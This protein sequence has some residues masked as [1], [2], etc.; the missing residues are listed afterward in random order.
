MI[1]IGERFPQQNLPS[2]FLVM[3]TFSY[4]I[5]IIAV[6]V[7]LLIAFLGKQLFVIVPV[8][9][10]AVAT[11]FGKPQSNIF[12]EGIHVPVNPLYD[13]TFFDT[14]AKTLKE[15]AAVPSQD[16]LKTSI[17]VSVQYRIDGSKA[18]KILQETGRAENAIEIH[19]KPK[20]RSLLREQGKTIKNAEDFFSD[21]TQTLLQGTLQESLSKF[22]DDKGIIV[23]EVL[24]R[25]INLPVS[26]QQQIEQKKETEQ[27]VQKEKAELLR[28]ETEAQQIVVQAIA[29]RSA[30]E[31]EAERRKLL[32][33]AQAYE[34]KKFNEALSSNPA[35]IQIQALEALKEISKDDSSKIYFLNGDSP[36]PL[37]LMHIGEVQKSRQP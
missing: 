7:V 25:D 32:A 3:K 22:L 4:Y 34:I 26:L 17:D 37:P 23:T 33:D 1:S 15:S 16:Q 31:Q 28:K 14:R 36:T 21:K 5:G 6:V 8:G 24:I 19:L 12:P 30:A 18:I 29:E 27:K 10:V 2:Y 20:L 9:H 35:Y 13:W 11:L